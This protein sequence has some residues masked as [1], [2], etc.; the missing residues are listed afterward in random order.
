MAS[1]TTLSTHSHVMQRES[2][3]SSRVKGCHG[4]GIRCFDGC[5]KLSHGDEI[6]VVVELHIRESSKHDT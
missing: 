6:L 3:Y 1:T 5:F 2:M 4:E